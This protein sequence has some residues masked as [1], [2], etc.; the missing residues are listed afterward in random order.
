METAADDGWTWAATHHHADRSGAEWHRIDLARDPERCCRSVAFGDR[1][2]PRC[3]VGPDRR[4]A[5][6]GGVV[7]RRPGA[8]RASL[9]RHRLRRPARRPYVET[10]LAEPVNEYGAAKLPRR[11]SP[12]QTLGGRRPHVSSGAGRATAGPIHLVRDPKIRF[13]TDEFRN[14][15]AVDSLAAVDRPEISGLLHIADHTAS[16]ASPSHR[17]SLP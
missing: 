8:A 15:L 12:P 4:T 11:P 7:V 9:V 14:P 17:P 5:G 16:I 6:T 2:R 10:D 3:A 13:F 1:R